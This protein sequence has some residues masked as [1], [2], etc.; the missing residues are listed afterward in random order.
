MGIVLSLGYTSYSVAKQTVESNA[1]SANQQTVEQTAEKL[2]VTLLRF[3]D[4]LSQL[5]YNKDIQ[6]AVSQQSLTA[7]G[8]TER[9]EQA[10]IISG[11]LN[12][13]LAWITNVEAVY[14][15]S[16]EDELP[17]VSAGAVNSDFL[18]GI[19]GSAWY[20]QLKEKPQSLWLTEALKQGEAEGV[21][22]FAKSMAGEAG[23]A[24]YIAVCDIKTT[25]LDG[26]LSKVDL[27]MD[28][29]VQLLTTGDELI[30]SSQHQEADTYL[31]LGGTLFNGLSDTSGSLP[32]KD[33]LGK[34]IL[35]VY[36]TLQSSGWRV[37]GV[38]PAENLLQ[39][40]GRILNTT[41]IA[42]A[43]AALIAVLIGLWMVRMV[44]HPLSRLR[45]LM[46][47]G[48]EGDLR[49]RTAVVSRDEI[50]Q[51]S[52]SFNMMM[53]RITELVVHTNET[54]REVLET[55]DALGNASRKTAASAKDIAAA[56]EEI[57]GGAGNLALEADRGH[58]MTALINERMDAV[59]AAAEGMG[60]SAHQAEQASREGVV[61][62]QELLGRTRE[63]GDMTGKLVVKVNELKDTA[64]SVI[65][66]L[67]VMQSITQQTNILSFNAT[68]EAAR[69]GEA[70]KGFMVV[71]DE[72]RQLA[73]QSKR[74]IAMVAEITDRIMSD[75][76]ET[77]DALS[78]VAPLFSEQ[79]QD[80]QSTS[81]IFLSVQGQMNQFIDRLDSVSSSIEG[82]NQS[83][84]VLSQTIGNVSSFAEESSAASEEVAS[85]TG[86]QQSVSDYLVELSGNLENSS[87]KLKERL[88]KFSV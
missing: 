37:L 4:N 29:Y 87:I 17:V 43:A 58:E 34:S 86:E 57:A 71:A 56:T 41:Y 62:L 73:D 76:H 85:L 80:V 70:G 66:V 31:R 88:S 52:G 5:F 35:A 83:Q 13:W 2:D 63:T 50:G 14:L 8:S 38:V 79:I 12:H 59:I 84:R 23:D 53:E 45:D 30:A 44:S 7:A 40:A 69:A 36:G 28:S 26:L 81:D 21:F 42:V 75:M 82:L 64:S 18:S 9:Q 68:I 16:L 60:G 15:I 1:L 11:E 27:G 55:A 39:D 72:I 54:A 10:D 48:A 51:L 49:V 6:Q 32:T 24:G 22:H 67:E 20:K 46:F 33:E 25:E 47:R 74:S 78:E 19:R 65:Q 61:K 77:V 3:E